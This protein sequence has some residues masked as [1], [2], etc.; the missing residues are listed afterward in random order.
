ML[1]SCNRSS[2]C[3]KRQSCLQLKVGKHAYLSMLSLP[4]MMLG[5]DNKGAAI[6]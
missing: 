2:S 3:L 5:T 6:S 4:D 1:N